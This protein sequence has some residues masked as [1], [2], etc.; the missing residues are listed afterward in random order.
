MSI[1]K[2]SFRLLAIGLAGAMVLSASFAKGSAVRNDG[3]SDQEEINQSFSL[4]QGSKVRINSINGSV[5]V[6]TWDQPTADIHIVK[7]TSYGA[8]ELKR[9]N[10]IID[11]TANSLD[12]RTRKDNEDDNVQVNVT[13]EVK[14]PR[15]M[16]LSVSGVNGKTD[17]GSVE[18]VVSAHGINGHLTIQQ[19][20][21]ELSVDGIN[22]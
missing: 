13:V 16:D 11:H 3:Y 10:V 15:Q 1:L 7:R 20:S 6:E 19:S 2:S 5:K 21:D 4:S 17:I 18:G 22:G 8:E 9:L 12:I 14:L